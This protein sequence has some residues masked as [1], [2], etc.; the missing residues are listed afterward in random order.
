MAESS[1][2]QHLC[3]LL[4]IGRRRAWHDDAG[5]VER[6]RRDRP[7]GNGSSRQLEHSATPQEGWR[8]CSV[9]SE[10]TLR[11]RGIC[12]VSLARLPVGGLYSLK[13]CRGRR[14]RHVGGSGR[15]TKDTAKR[16]FLLTA[17]RNHTRYAMGTSSRRTKCFPMEDMILTFVIITFFCPSVTFSA[18]IN[19][20]SGGS[21][22]HHGH[23]SLSS[24]AIGPCVN[25]SAEKAPRQP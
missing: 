11:R 14:F 5:H 7:R 4:I 15:L 8:A 6:A 3:D 25:P 18:G 22:G 21:Y 23:F 10:M 12:C 16:K 19:H 2:A 24:H 9:R 13:E 17:R 20:L 1:S